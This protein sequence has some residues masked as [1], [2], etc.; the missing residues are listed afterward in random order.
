MP[1][2]TIV[3]ALMPPLSADVEFAVV[4][5]VDLAVGFSDGM[6]GKGEEVGVPVSDELLGGAG[7]EIE[8]GEEDE[9]TEGGGGDMVD[10]AGVG[11]G[12]RGSEPDGG[13][14]EGEF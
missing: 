1:M 12:E 6:E 4:F 5:V 13:G 14:G 9:G 3:P 7:G 11:G 2:V 8:G 10:L